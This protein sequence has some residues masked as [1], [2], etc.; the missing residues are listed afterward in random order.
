MG[1]FQCKLQV[2]SFTTLFSLTVYTLLVL[3]TLLASWPEGFIPFYLI[4]VILL[5]FECISSQ[6]KI[7]S[8]KGS[9]IFRT[10]NRLH[11][12]GQDWIVIKKPWTFSRYG[13]LLMLEQENINIRKHLWLAYDNMTEPEWRQLRQ[14]IFLFDSRSS[15]SSI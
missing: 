4:I 12:R 6:K 2:S 3:L 11:W 8:Y 14:F 10:D 15:C 7:N 5:V 1:Q 13:L 9:I